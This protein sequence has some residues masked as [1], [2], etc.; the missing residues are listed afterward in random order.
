MRQAEDQG[1]EALN[2][3]KS[4][5]VTEEQQDAQKVSCES[6]NLPAQLIVWLIPT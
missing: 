6:D 3:F 4:E 1:D 5:V 2:S